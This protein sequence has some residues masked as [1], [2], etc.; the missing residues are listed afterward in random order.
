MVNQVIELV[1]PAISSLIKK[2]KITH[3]VF[4]PSTVKRKVQLMSEVSKK[5]DM[6]VATI[7]VTKIIGEV[8]IPQKSLKKLADR[9]QNSE[10]SFYIASKSLLTDKPKVLIIDDAVGSGAT[11]NTIAQMIK[12]KYHNNI[13]IYGFAFVGSFKGFE[14]ISE[15]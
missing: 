12:Q 13:K 15:V 10:S 6:G 5:I 11:I 7:E 14:V 2:H 9:I 8:G 3:L 1:T 4:V